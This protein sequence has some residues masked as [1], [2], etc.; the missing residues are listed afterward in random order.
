MYRLS[1]CLSVLSWV[2][3]SPSSGTKSTTESLAKVVVIFH[4]V[5][6]S[7]GVS[8]TGSIGF[9]IC[10]WCSIAPSTIL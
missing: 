10:D 8:F 5:P 6:S 7:F 9:P 4:C 1:V 2:E 3:A